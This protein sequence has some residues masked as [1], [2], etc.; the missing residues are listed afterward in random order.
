MEYDFKKGLWH[1]ETGLQLWPPDNSKY[2]AQDPIDPK[3]FAAAGRK[4][5][6]GKNE[7]AL[8]DPEFIEGLG[9][10]LTHGG[11]VYG[12]YNWQKGISYHRVFSACLRHLYAWWRGQDNDPDTGLSHLY[13]CAA[14]V[15]FL[16]HF[17][18]NK[19][20]YKEFDDRI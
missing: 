4:D 15:M 16:A 18:K 9:A 7:L 20:K 3:L 8:I 19:E 5:D 14:N 17:H 1:S 2:W 13:H 10:V 11:K 6:T 12:K